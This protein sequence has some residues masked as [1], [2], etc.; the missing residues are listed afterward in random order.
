MSSVMDVLPY[1]P[2]LLDA[3]LADIDGTVAKR[4]ARQII[5][6][7]DEA[8]LTIKVKHIF[9]TKPSAYHRVLC[10]IKKSK[11]TLIINTK[12]DNGPS[13]VV[14]GMN[15]QLRIEDA[16][17]FTKLDDLT[18]NIRRQILNASD[19]RFCSPKCEGKRYIFTYHGTEYTKCQ[20]LCSNFRLR[21][22]DENDV[23]SVTTLV[24]QELAFVA[25]KK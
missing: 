8:G 6:L 21:V 12:Q 9:P 1:S 5:K 3:I 11:E 14:E 17:S 20:M 23:D 22:T 18:D 16:N 19:C 4:T 13:G 2:D 24:E 25:H 10:Y 7:F 15:I